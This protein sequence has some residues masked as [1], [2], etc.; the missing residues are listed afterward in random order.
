MS[1][2]CYCMSR[3]VLSN[4]SHEQWINRVQNL[5]DM[6]QSCGR[7]F[8][9]KSVW[10]RHSTTWHSFFGNGTMPCGSCRVWDARVPLV[11]QYQ[12]LVSSIH[13][14]IWDGSWSESESEWERER[15]ASLPYI[16]SHTLAD[17]VADCSGT[18]RMN[19]VALKILCHQNIVKRPEYVSFSTLNVHLS[20]PKRSIDNALGFPCP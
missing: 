20:C 11:F 12:Y 13:W 3:A 4:F 9:V 15:G 1:F 10:R 14:N 2:E 17:S 19:Q 18:H 7:Q 5:F 8:Y 6:H 16:A